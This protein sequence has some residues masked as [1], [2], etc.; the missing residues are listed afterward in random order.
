MKEY[1]F[2]VAERPGYFGK[3]RDEIHRNYDL[4]YGK[5]NWKIGWVIGENMKWSEKNNTIEGKYHVFDF[6]R[7]CKLYEDAYYKYFENYE[8][9]LGWITKNASEVY[10]NDISNINSGLD[11]SKQE[12]GIGTHIQDIAIRNVAARFG[13]AFEGEEILQIRTGG[14]GKKM[15][16]RA[17]TVSQA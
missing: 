5:G 8:D 13:K 15:E 1:T 16:S 17:Y 7:A 10:D 6:L 11:Y 9:E 3:R 12:E 4:K 2:S 14:I